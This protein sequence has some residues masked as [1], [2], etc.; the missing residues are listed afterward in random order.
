MLHARPDYNR[1]QDP[2]NKIPAGEPV[3]LLRGQD[4]ASIAA[5]IAWAEASELMGVSPDMIALA[6]QQLDR[7][8]EWQRLH[9]SKVADLPGINSPGK[10]AKEGMRLLFMATKSDGPHAFQLPEV[11]VFLDMI[12]VAG[13]DFPDG[14]HIMKVVNV[15]GGEHRAARCKNLLRAATS[16][17][18]NIMGGILED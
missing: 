14:Q 15:E 11:G 13:R 8:R 3:F 7:I 12:L 2:E 17:L 6:R 18:G 4:K 9:A 10:E 5:L 1:I 16:Q